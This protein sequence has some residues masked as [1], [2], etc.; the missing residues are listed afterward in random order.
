VTIISS[1]P[2]H[3]PRY[4]RSNHYD[5]QWV[6]DNQMGPNALWLIEALTQVI[7][8]EPDLSCQR[9]RGSSLGY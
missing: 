5:P 8:I 9:V 7:E 1:N 4:L 2:L 3:H 6:L